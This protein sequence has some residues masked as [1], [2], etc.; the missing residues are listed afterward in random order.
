M[1]R[2]RE[3]LIDAE[4]ITEVPDRLIIELKN[5]VRD[6][7]LRYSEPVDDMLA[8]KLRQALL[9]DGGQGN[10]L[11]PLGEVIHRYYGELEPFGRR[12][13]W[14]ADVDSLFCEGP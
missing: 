8:D 14:T 5:I 1:V 11:G 10:G 7:G 4:M 3:V 12:W 2:C 9:G 13:Q 6:Q